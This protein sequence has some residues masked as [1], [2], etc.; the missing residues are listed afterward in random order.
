M[1]TFRRLTRVP[2]LLAAIAA[3]AALITVIGLAIGPHSREALFAV[4]RERSEVEL[5]LSPG[6]QRTE[7]YD[8]NGKEIGILRYDIDRE[9]I[10][11]SQVPDDVLGTLLAVE[12]NKFWTHNGVDIRAISRAMIQNLTSGAIT[13]GGSTITQQIVK[14]RIVGNESSLS[15]K[16][17]EAV[18]AA[19]L[20]EEFSK[21]QILEFY[22]NEIYFGNGAYGLQAAAET[23]FG[24]DVDQLDVGDAA[25]LAGLI[26]STG[27]FDGFG[28]VEIVGKRR[29]M[30]LQSAE[31]AG[32]IDADEREEFEKRGLP[33]RNLS[34]QKVDETLRRDYFLDEVTEALLAHPALGESYQERF[35]KVY[36]GG[37][38]VWTTFDPLLQRKMEQAV[39]DVLPEG[40]G[41]FEV[42][43]ASVD[44]ASG[45]VRAFI[46]GPEFADFQFNLVT[47][48]RRQP[49]SSFK[50]YVLAA[51]VEKAGLLPYDT[52][53]GIGPCTFPNPPNVD[54]EVNNFN[55]SAG[56]VGTVQYAVLK[57]SNCGFVR[58]G[59]RTGLD[60]VVEV[61]NRLLG[62][63]SENSFRPYLSMSLGAQEVTPLE[64][65]VA[66]G[67]IANGGLRMEPYFISKIED[68]EGGVIY[69]H[70]P[71]GRRAIKGDTAAWVSQVLAQNVTAGTG[72]RAALESGQPSAGKTGTA[73][74]FSD[75]WYVG[76]TPQL[77]TAVWMGHPEEKVSMVDVQGRAGTGG[78]VTARIWGSYMSK[79]LE[80]EEILPLLEPPPP[81]R[82]SQLLYLSDERCA[83]NIELGPGRGAMEFDLPC[84]MTKVDLEEGIFLPHPEA[85]CRITELS[86]S[87]AYRNE[88][89]NCGL[90]PS[91]NPVI[92]TPEAPVGTS[93]GD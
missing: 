46:G 59:L 72:R 50:T 24:K 2:I 69:Q 79:A 22:L 88:Y 39:L 51:A 4:D 30:S 12:D 29:S 84:A 45:A 82:S 3:S 44:P 73:Q 33:D 78:W 90:V 61:S 86:A 11:I 55:E 17:R 43:V 85:N 38:R 87:G 75:A 93:A 9:L 19:R 63:D 52:I 89:L 49:G 76:F 80:G 26:R 14:L 54:Y 42:A 65:A 31:A 5:N 71:R 92:E 68:A 58:L 83:V 10:T 21:E 18:L 66:Y 48:G 40:T 25:L 8:S 64:Q 13:Q 70:V 15:R 67:A 56:V 60:N 47:Q 6:A 37:L 62:R 16:I 35:A 41:D 81:Q 27:I 28:D 77:S 36:N 20:E 53:S 32:I 7:V 91:R 23:Y 1:R 74:D 34:P 57:S